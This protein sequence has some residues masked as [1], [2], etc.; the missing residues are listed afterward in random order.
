MLVADTVTRDAIPA[1]FECWYDPPDTRSVP[2]G[3]MTE[4][5]STAAVMIDRFIVPPITWK[6]SD[7]PDGAC[8]AR[9]AAS[10]APSET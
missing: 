9:P 5:V 2:S 7:L 4:T 10:E 3:A 8:R 1:S 6:R